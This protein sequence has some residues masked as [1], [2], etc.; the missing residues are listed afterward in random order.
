M[1]RIKI[2]VTTVLLFLCGV[3]AHAQYEIGDM[4]G[5]FNVSEMGAA[6]Y[7]LPFDLPEGI[8]GMKPSLGLVYNSQGG[9]GVAGMGMSISGLSVISRTP[10]DIFHDGTAKGIS[11]TTA[12]AYAKD[13]VRLLLKSG[14][15][16]NS[17]A[18]YSVEGL[19][20]DDITLMGSGQSQSFV[21]NLP[22]GSKA[23]YGTKTIFPVTT[24]PSL[25][26][27]DKVVDVYGNTV[28]YNYSKS[29]NCVYLT[30]V[31]YGTNE[32]VGTN[33]SASV[34]FNYEN[35][36][37]T[38]KSI[39]RAYKCNMSR[40]LKSV[41]VKTTQNSTSTTWYTYNLAY[42]Y[43]DGFS[44][45]KT[46]TKTYE[47]AQLP[48]VTFTWQGMSGFS[49]TRTAIKKFGDIVAKDDKGVYQSITG[50]EDRLN[51]YF[52]AGNF[53]GN[54]KSDIV[55]ATP[56]KDY[57]YFNIYEYGDDGIFRA[58]SNNEVKADP[59]DYHQLGNYVGDVDGDG[60]SEIIM[61]CTSN[62]YFGVYV[63]DKMKWRDPIAISGAYPAGANN[64][65]PLDK[66]FSEK[67]VVNCK[68]IH[69][70]GDFYNC[71]RMQVI[72]VETEPYN[73]EYTCKILM[74][75]AD[76][77]KTVSSFKMYVP[78]APRRLI[79]SDFNGDGLPDLMVVNRTGYQ[80]YINQGVAEGEMPFL[81]TEQ[82]YGSEVCE[83]QNVQTGDFNG[84]GVLDFLI[85][86]KGDDNWYFCFG[87]GNGKFTKKLACNLP[88]CTDKD[89]TERDNDKLHCY[90]TDFNN[91][92]KSDVIIVKAF[93]KK[94]K[95]WGSVWGEY[96]E[97]YTYWMRST[98]NSLAV[99]K[100]TTTS[101]VNDASPAH[102]TVGDFDGDGF[103]EIITFGNDLL[104]RSTSLSAW[105]LY[106]NKNLTAASN[107]ISKIS[108]S[109]YG[110]E[111]LLTYASLYDKT[112]Y[113]KG[114]DSKFPLV[115][116]TLP[117]HVVKQST[118]NVGGWSY[119]MDYS[120]AG[121][122]I[123]L[124]GRGML[125]FKST[126]TYD[127]GTDKRETRTVN[128][129][130]A[131]WFIPKEITT[132]TKIIDSESSVKTTISINKRNAN[133]YFAY[134]STIEQADVYGN[135][136]KTQNS[137]NVTY[138][139]QTSQR[140]DY[141]T[142]N[143][144]Y[145][146]T[147]YSSYV[148]VGGVYKP[149]YV[150]TTQ[151]HKDASKV[152]TV[153]NRSEY[154]SKGAVVKATE[155]ANSVPNY[156]TYTYDIFGNV[157]SHSLWASGIDTV[158]TTYTYDATHRFI[159]EEKSNTS[160]ISMTYTYNELDLPT[161]T[162]KL[163]DGSTIEYEQYTYDNI[164]R[165]TSVKTY[166]QV[167]TSTYT[168]GWGSSAKKRYYIKEECTA[169]P[170]VVTWYDNVNRP[171]LTETLG[172]D[173]VLITKEKL[174]D[175]NG[176]IGKIT[177][178]TGNTSHNVLY[179]YDFLERISMEHSSMGTDKIYVYEN[180]KVKEF[181]TIPAMTKTFDEW[182][183]IKTI[184]DVDGASVQYTYNSNG[185]AEKIV[186]DGAVFQMEYDAK[187]QQT[188][189]TDADAGKTT[190]TYDALGRI[191]KQVDYKGI[192]TTNTY[193]KSGLLTKTTCGDVTTTYTYDT[194]QRLISETTGSESI[195]YQYN[196]KN[197]L[198]RKTI[199]V[200]ST[201]DLVFRYFYNALNQNYLMYYPDNTSERYYYDA[202][203]NVNRVV[204]NGQDVWK[205]TSNNGRTRKAQLRD[206]L[207]R[208]EYRAADGYLSYTS[209]MYKSSY[210]NNLSYNFDKK[211]NLLLSRNS[212]LTGRRTEYFSY[213]SH[214]RLVE[215]KISGNSQYVEYAPNGN[216][217]EK[218]N[219]GTYTY[220]S[221]RPHAVIEVE[222]YA[223]TVSEV[224]Q[225]ITYTPFNKV[226]TVSQGDYQLSI[227]YGS[228]RQRCKTELS[229]ND[230]LLYT[231]YYADNYEEVHE[232]NNVYRYYYVY[233]PD[234]LSA[235]AEKKNT[236]M[237]IYS[238]ETD[239]LGS[240][241]S[242]YNTKGKMAFRA[243]Y[244]A[245]GRQNVVVDSLAR[246]QR[247]YCGHEHWHEFD[248]VDMNGRMYDPVIARFLSPDPFVQAPED[249]QNYNRYS[250]CLNNPLKYSDPSGESIVA[251]AVIIGALAGAYFGGALANDS[252][253]MKEWDFSSSETWAGMFWGAVVGGVSGC[254]GGA[255]ATS[256]MPFA[257]TASIAGSSILNSSG[258]YIVSGGKSS[259]SMSF[260]FASYDF[261]NNEWGYLGKKGNSKLENL[262]YFIG[263]MGLLNDINNVINQT[264]ATLYT[265]EL[266]DDG[267][268]D[269]ISHTGIVEDK[270]GKTL[271]SFGPND[272]KIGGGGFKD[273]IGSAKPLGGYKKFGVAIRKGTPE[274]YV[275]T[276]L[277]KSTS[278]V[279]NKY[280]FDGLRKVSKF[281]PYQGLTTN[282]VNMSSI[283]L[284]LNGIPNIGIH[285]Y[286]LHYNIVAYNNW[287]VNP[288]ILSPL[289]TK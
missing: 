61:P 202:I 258:T 177:S 200:D 247:G 250:Y 271:M 89:Y 4:G 241:V 120:Y 5:V 102:F 195:S 260:G 219:I 139:Y 184:T 155:Y 125:G 15:N 192:V 218:T 51:Q 140:T 118:Q 123:H 161:K 130:D 226:A 220:D 264:N 137:Y 136:T 174:Y 235:V 95:S 78:N 248:L 191:I 117:I 288:Y 10:K 129:L 166:P 44:R 193:D 113:T 69:T 58:K 282:C 65:Q 64:S 239:Y 164:G 256:G 169:S 181:G 11:Y 16:G 194:R 34:V 215:T 262:G 91:D 255:I 275:P 152:F 246:F 259:V 163:L 26:Y 283:G 232:G 188:S 19:P 108:T 100:K 277:S 206:S 71:G 198:T 90:V 8:N 183:N 96:Q 229:R 221:N 112:V 23:Y 217:T 115:D 273:L 92:G 85:E 279:V 182:G 134:P 45:L 203:G 2:A 22:D 208:Y 99:Q 47:S 1:K 13:G 38:V 68:P 110:T 14:S 55:V 72:Y 80:I 60:Q 165:R 149:Q 28:T 39:H 261:T 42:Q 222:N 213:D 230:T 199:T 101:N 27:L 119:V 31:T 82:V 25:W 20:Y 50:G 231:R 211:K 167:T 144:M 87:N 190:Y 145:K 62:G 107:K 86:S 141:G 267:S 41:V 204:F 179:S 269:I 244:D 124:R 238:S 284:W 245:W 35:R 138:G 243:E 88:D 63:S 151:K 33:F 48:P 185:N 224:P 66:I 159:F 251:G 196:T 6:T 126:T 170:Y 76:G 254:A 287:G 147:T 158:T 77:T 142:S 93:Y 176:K 281:I 103:E 132:T 227:T 97:T 46:V 98:G 278:L 49:L 21:A 172:E 157:L 270:S 127:E 265:Q 84:D 240:I 37:D 162:S 201:R 209:F 175:R 116:V 36:S 104:G 133:N 52:F 56:Y 9:N 109:N 135:K 74:K 75:K 242:L 236:T 225:Y 67:L 146:M 53:L 263:S 268:L 29:G 114:T 43:T 286:L 30:S 168:Y 266:N 189:L 178:T 212:M 12:D 223:G 253:K 207:Y 289:L 57:T 40:R 257:N 276:Y 18:I 205:L 59:I 237:N 7:S 17:G 228:D 274:Y 160:G 131:N 79:A 154:N 94:K 173:S 3:S 143:N 83:V 171:V 233:T 197:Q 32:S 156:H 214:D 234:G 252:Y 70:I 216:I 111:T 128:S 187:G 272:D 280:I 81:E 186:A 121:L 73:R 24:A 122:R 153:Q 148:K 249:L 285:P 210:L 106:D 180:M 54:G 150:T 105:N